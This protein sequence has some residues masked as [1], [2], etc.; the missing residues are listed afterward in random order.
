MKCPKCGS[1]SNKVV[2]SRN[3][4]ERV[5]RT[6]K[7]EDCGERFSTEEIYA[8]KKVDR[9]GRRIPDPV[10]I[11]CEIC[12]KDVVTTCRQTKYCEECR[13][14]ARIYKNAQRQ[15]TVKDRNIVFHKSGIP[16]KNEK[17]REKNLSY[18][19]LEAQKWLKNQK[20]VLESD[21]E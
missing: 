5:T 6:R 11:K 20:S 13:K 15:T 7:C 19:Q 21:G 4:E 16:D 1:E 10:T 8:S 12:N 9:K 17:A 2:D 18:G 14:V 3:H